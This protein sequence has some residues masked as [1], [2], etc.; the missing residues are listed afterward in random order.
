[1]VSAVWTDNVTQSSNKVVTNQ[2][3]RAGL[4][5]QAVL[6]AAVLWA[7]TAQA[8]LISSVGSV[9]GPG[10]LSAT[11]SPLFTFVPNNDDVGAPGPN[12]IGIEKTLQIF[13]YVDIEFRVGTTGGT[14]EYYMVDSANNQ[15]PGPW[16][17]YSMQLGF[18][19]GAGFTPS[20]AGDG[21]DFDGPV[22]APALTSGDFTAL[23]W[24]PDRFD[25]TGGSVG[26]G[27]STLFTFSIDVPDF[28]S[29]TMPTSALIPGGY[30]FTL[31]QLPIVVPEPGSIAFLALFGL[32]PLRRRRPA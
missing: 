22:P 30:K 29:G 1:L 7:G 27:L 23:T 18:G 26:V 10:L 4:G 14:T 11:V 28:D 20:V 5:R 3:R 8:G 15:T 25:W 6:L 12:F 2:H 21:L 16:D 13:D 31:R 9:S 24:T 17:R 32:L 19:T